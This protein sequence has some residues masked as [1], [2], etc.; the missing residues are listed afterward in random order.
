MLSLTTWRV[1]SKNILFN[2]KWCTKLFVVMLRSSQRSGYC[3]QLMW[4]EPSVLDV[5]PGCTLFTDNQYKVSITR[6]SH[7]GFCLKMFSQRHL[8]AQHCPDMFHND[9]MIFRLWSIP[10]GGGGRG[11]A[12]VEILTGMLVLFFGFEI[13]TNPIFWVGKFFSYFSGFRK[14]SAIFFWVWQ[15][16]SYVFGS[17][18]CCITH[19]NPLNEKHTVLKNIK[20]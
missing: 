1:A 16:S 18:N 7:S 15:I 13:W 5:N 11:G 4:H 10:G 17:S 2:G 12:H 19:L 6:L 3:L 9:V 20:S 14:I 8:N